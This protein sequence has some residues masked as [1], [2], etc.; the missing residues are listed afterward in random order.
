MKEILINDLVNNIGGYKLLF[1][2][3]KDEFLNLDNYE[4]IEDLVD[5]LIDEN[6]DK[7][8]I[9]LLDKCRA[10]ITCFVFDEEDNDIVTY[11]NKKPFKD[12]EDIIDNINEFVTNIL[13]DYKPTVIGIIQETKD[14]KY[15]SLKA[16]E[17]STN[18]EFW[19]ALLSKEIRC[20]YC[21]EL[22]DKAN[23]FSCK[24]GDGYREQD[25]CVNF[26]NGHIMNLWDYFDMNINP[27][28]MS[29]YQAIQILN[30][31]LQDR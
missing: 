2:P 30:Y 13:D 15:K 8:I 28:E 7:T 24:N 5:S 19:D 11:K 4:N 26:K 9:F 12:D 17:D 27:S 10:Y 21:Q 31:E 20:R 3:K 1:N 16:I 29:K 14:N 23:S 18:E 6:E 25:W 22:M